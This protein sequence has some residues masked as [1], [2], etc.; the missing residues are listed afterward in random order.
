MKNTHTYKKGDRVKTR[1]SGWVGVVVGS[2]FGEPEKGMLRI[3][4]SCGLTH[5]FRPSQLELTN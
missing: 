1:S 5:D 4:L 3:H 2:S